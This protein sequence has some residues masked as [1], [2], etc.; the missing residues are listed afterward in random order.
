MMSY[1]L[2]EPFRHE[3]KFFSSLTKI[4]ENVILTVKAFLISLTTAHVEMPSGPGLLGYTRWYSPLGP[5][6]INI[7]SSVRA[8][9]L[10]NNSN[11]LATKTGRF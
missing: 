2:L 1:E 4:L 3:R 5:W 9:G 6:L 10:G 7:D 8:C 11:S